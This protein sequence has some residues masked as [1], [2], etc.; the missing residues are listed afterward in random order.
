MSHAQVLILITNLDIYFKGINGL[1]DFRVKRKAV[2]KF[3]F[4]VFK[5]FFQELLSW[6]WKS[7]SSI[8]V[9]K[10]IINLH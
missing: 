6:F 7:Y 4:T 5:A 1:R 8:T 10:I 2:P 9:S 3:C